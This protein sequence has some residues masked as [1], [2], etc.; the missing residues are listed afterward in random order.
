[1]ELLGLRA[2]GVRAWVRAEVFCIRSGPGP[3]APGPAPF[4]HALFLAGSGVFTSPAPAI[5]IVDFCISHA[6][7]GQRSAHKPQCTHMSSSLTMTRPVCLRGTETYK[8]C[9]TL[10]AGALSCLRSSASGASATIVK[11]SVGQMSMQASH[12][13]H[14]FA[15][16]TVCTSQF[17][18]R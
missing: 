16:N 2:W 18:Q 12:S 7:V 10:V 13:M 3:Q 8:S 14:S 11:Q 5:L 9:V 6:Y 17:K 1:M 15:S 4:R